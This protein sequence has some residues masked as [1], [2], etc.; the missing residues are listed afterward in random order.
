[1]EELQK[2]LKDNNVD[3]EIEPSAQQ[4]EAAK[5]KQEEEEKERKEKKGD[6]E[7]AAVGKFVC[8]WKRY[9]GSLMEDGS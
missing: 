6:E 1:M 5:K 3:F 7:E 8:S 4:L 2:F 9:I